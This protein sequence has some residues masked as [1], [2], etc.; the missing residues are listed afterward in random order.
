MKL[1][2]NTTPSGD[3]KYAAVRLRDVAAHPERPALLAA[4]ARLDEAGVLDRGQVNAPDEFFLI[5]LK[6]KYAQ[7][8]LD[9]YAQAAA[10]DD[11]EYAAE[12]ERLAARSGP[13]HP[14]CKR[15]D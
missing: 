9:A 7:S 8:A 2:R 4:L 11:V 14:L 15:P 5:R 6:D 13:D 3:G 12:I 10:T 1:D